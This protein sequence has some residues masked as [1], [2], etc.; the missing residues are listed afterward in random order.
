MNHKSALRLEHVRD[1]KAQLRIDDKS[2]IYA[3]L[4]GVITHRN[5][6]GGILFLGLQD[7]TGS[8]QLIFKHDHFSDAEWLQVKSLRKTDFILAEGFVDVQSQEGLPDRLSL[9]IT[10]NPIPLSTDLDIAVSEADQPY[11]RVGGQII[12]A[13]L[14]QRVCSVLSE[15]EFVEIEP[16]LISVNWSGVGL[17][18]MRIEYPGFGYYTYLAPTPVPQ[19]FEAMIATGLPR[20]YA[21]GKCFSTSYRDEKS[22][23]E[24]SV[25][26][27][28]AQDTDIGK[29]YWEY[30][31]KVM[32]SVFENVKTLPR[33][34]RTFDPHLWETKALKWPPRIEQMDVEVPTV[35]L[36]KRPD[37]GIHILT[38]KRMADGGLSRP[39]V[40]ELSRLVFPGRSVIVECAKEIRFGGLKVLTFSFHIERMAYLLENIPMRQLRSNTFWHDS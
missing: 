19:L 21:S 12:L 25:V 39:E 11:R 14:K 6:R 7:T 28:I 2:A 3:R 23:T 15:S 9:S 36:F 26:F 22:S 17:E 16:N 40:I 38:P 30:L 27:A 13:R 31:T 33:D 20:I 32:L 24:A 10:T 18:P 8:I 29:N 4:R 5:N 35:Q 1:I 37:L 34:T